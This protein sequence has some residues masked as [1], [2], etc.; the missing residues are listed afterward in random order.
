M[1]SLAALLAL[2]T[3]S[4]AYKET[5]EYQF[6][7]HETHNFDTIEYGNCQILDGTALFNFKA[8]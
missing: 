4:N 3:V 2:G 8:L 6:L 1:R 7:A 5:L